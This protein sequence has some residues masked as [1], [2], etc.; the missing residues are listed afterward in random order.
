MI[1]FV[2]DFKVHGKRVLVRVDFNVPLKSING[3]MTVSDDTRIREALPTIQYLVG[4]GAKV[5]LVSHLGRPEGRDPSLS[6][7][8][9]AVRLSELLGHDGKIGGDVLF[10]DDCV[11]DGI[12]MIIKHLK[13]SQVILLENVRYHK[14]EE[15]NDLEFSQ[16]L[17][18]LGEIYINDAFGTA[19]RK[20]AS[21]YAVATLLTERGC[22]YLIQ[23]EL[24]FLNTLL[25]NP[26]SPYVAILGGSKVSDKIKTIENLYQKVDIML[27]G[28]AM[29][30]AFRLALGSYELPSGVKKPK[31]EDID[32]ARK[33]ILKAKNSEVDLVLPI[34]DIDSFDIG[35]K[36]I[37]LF[38]K[39]L[40]NAQT[41]FWNG[42]LGMFE[43]PE[44]AKGTFAVALAMAETTGLKVIGGGDTVSAIH[45][46]G[47]ATKMDHIST[48]GGATLEFLEGRGLPGIEILNTYAKKA[49]NKNLKL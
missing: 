47:V 39:K 10:T 6:L 13:G 32:Y 29:S 14:E 20:H 27:I 30:N 17:A 34:D 44:F 1:K 42:P 24:K 22:G 28:G 4:H 11:G 36:T 41:V 18:H 12:E 21:T 43:K 3:V 25:E 8:P 49:E 37:D 16:K 31:P 23:K 9:V 2:E 38:C 19:H 46:S 5:I 45:L 33:L 35:P 7:E 15:E 48:G 26:K 40:A